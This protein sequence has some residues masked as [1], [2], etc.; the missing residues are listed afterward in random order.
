MSEAVM[1]GVNLRDR[2]I[3]VRFAEPVDTIALTPEQ[4]RE[5]AASLIESAK[6]I[7][8]AAAPAE[9]PRRAKPN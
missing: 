2:N 3:M 4:A 5:L 1:I 9:E 7:E 8:H 6:E